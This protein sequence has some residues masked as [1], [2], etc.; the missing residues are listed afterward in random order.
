MGLAGTR[1]PFVVIHETPRDGRGGRRAY[2][3]PAALAPEQRMDAQL[4]VAYPLGGRLLDPHPERRL[5]LSRAP[6]V[7]GRADQADQSARSSLRHLK[8]GQQEGSELALPNRPNNFFRK[9]G[10]HS[11][12]GLLW[13]PDL[14]AC[15]CRA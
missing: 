10:S 13:V 12:L 3:S 11:R 8:A 5:V 6:I 14:G 1:R 2:D 7:E 4:A 9:P 15:A